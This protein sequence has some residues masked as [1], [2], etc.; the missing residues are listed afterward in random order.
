MVSRSD[1]SQCKLRLMAKR[2]AQQ[3]RLSCSMAKI[4]RC[5]CTAS[6]LSAW[7][8]W[9]LIFSRS[10][11]FSSPVDRGC[12]AHV[13]RDVSYIDESSS[14]SSGAVAPKYL[15]WNLSGERSAILL[16]PNT[17]VPCS[18]FTAALSS[19]SSTRFSWNS[20][21]R[22]SQSLLVGYCIRCKA[23]RNRLVEV[24]HVS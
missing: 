16:I 8:A 24:A 4:N 18:A 10:Y 3:L 2:Q 6:L 7:S 11:V 22:T 5:Q 21:N 13:C 19:S 23:S 20:L 15:D 1:T 14:N 12:R 17:A 9:S